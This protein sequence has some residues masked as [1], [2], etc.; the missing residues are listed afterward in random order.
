MRS[1]LAFTALCL[2][3]IAGCAH[4]TRTA[5]ASHSSGPKFSSSDDDAFIQYA[6]M[7]A[8]GIIDASEAA[9]HQASSSATRE[10]ARTIADD[11]R[12]TLQEL[13]R[14]AGQRKLTL[15]SEPDTYHR[16]LLARLPQYNNT[17]F[18]RSYLATM[19][20]DCETLLPIYD[21]RATRAS[22]KQVRSLATQTAAQL[23][24]NLGTIQATAVEGP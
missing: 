9:T 13:N 6:A 15:P 17:D 12:G 8:H 10:L 1:R 3:L 24:Q 19:A 23:R 14:L 16:E 18:D 11:Q 22:T 4:R 21:D 7:Q 2:I 5:A 20:H